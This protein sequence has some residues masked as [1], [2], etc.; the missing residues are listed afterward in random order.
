MY[1][2]LLSANN[3]YY[4]I[5]TQQGQVIAS[6]RI[7][8]IV[9]KRLCVTILKSPNWFLLFYTSLPRLTMIESKIKNLKIKVCLRFSAH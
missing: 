9:I 8:R 1:L 2:L 7:T 6:Y 5:N 3:F 4:V